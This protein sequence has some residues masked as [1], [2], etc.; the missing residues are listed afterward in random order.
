MYKQLIFSC[1]CIVADV[2]FKPVVHAIKE[3]DNQRD[4]LLSGIEE[5]M[6]LLRHKEEEKMAYLVQCQNYFAQH[7]PMRAVRFIFRSNQVHE[8]QLVSLDMH[9]IEKQTALLQNAIVEKVSIA[10]L[11]NAITKDAHVGS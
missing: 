2:V 9:V 7:A 11:N 10:Q 8:P 1:L 5:R 4:G 3:E 6:Q